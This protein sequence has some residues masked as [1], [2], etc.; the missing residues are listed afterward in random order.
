MLV[1]EREEGNKIESDNF[2]IIKVPINKERLNQQIIYSKGLAQ[3]YRNYYR[4]TGYY[5][6]IYAGKK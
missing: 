1:Y 5:V 6:G 4:S 3:A 2:Q